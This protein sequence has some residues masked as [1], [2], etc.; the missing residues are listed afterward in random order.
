MRS[1]YA[2]I[3]CLGLAS[4]P[5]RRVGRTWYHK[6]AIDTARLQQRTSLWPMCYCGGNDPEFDKCVTKGAN[7]AIPELVKDKFDANVVAHFSPTEKGGE[8]YW[9][10]KNLDFD[11]KVSKL[12]MNLANLF[13]GDKAL[14]ECD[15]LTNALI[16]PNTKIMEGYNDEFGNI[17]AHLPPPQRT[18]LFKR[19]RSIAITATL[20]GL[21]LFTISILLIKHHPQLN[22][23]DNVY[24]AAIDSYNT[25]DGLLVLRTHPALKPKMKYILHIEYY[26]DLQSMSYGM[27]QISHF[28]DSNTDDRS[29]KTNRYKT[30]SLWSIMT[31]EASKANPSGYQLL[32]THL[33][34]EGI[35]NEWLFL[36]DF[37]ILKV[38]RKYDTS[39]VSFIQFLDAEEYIKDL[40]TP[41]YEVMFTNKNSRHDPHDH[42]NLLLRALIFDWAC[43]MGIGSC[44]ATAKFHFNSWH[45]S[46]NPDEVN[47]S[48]KFAKLEQISSYSAAEALGSDDLERV[49]YYPKKGWFL[50]RWQASVLAIGIILFIFAVVYTGRTT[51]QDVR[52][53]DIEI[54][55]IHHHAGIMRIDFKTPL[56]ASTIYELRIPYRGKVRS[57]PYGLFYVIDRNPDTMRDNFL[58]AT[59]S[60][61][62]YART[63]FPCFDV[64]E[65]NATY[66]ISIA[67]DHLMHFESSILANWESETTRESNVLYTTNNNSERHKR[68]IALVTA[69]HIAEQ[70]IESIITF[71]EDEDKW[72]NEQSFE[73]NT[74]NFIS[75]E[76]RDAADL[77]SVGSIV[78]IRGKEIFC[79]NT[80]TGGYAN[81]LNCS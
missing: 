48:A 62:P 39:E 56:E 52:S 23:E 13:N 72:L 63:I 51:H 55:E 15:K 28:K 24:E 1:I 64:H 21:I 47:P 35:V 18:A 14:G 80:F 67:Q 78:S 53:N 46:D 37:P 12:Y 70:W 16:D 20:A 49:S 79:F 71:P 54:D 3:L 29:D 59:N 22:T 69:A 27:F 61:T 11:F 41:V 10:L 58:I 25:D 75:K 76:E 8:T 43:K 57:L 30:D 38:V 19:F 6:A 66:E 31:D 33:T 4:G 68:K 34:L 17:D 5:A 2:C 77:L 44:Q 73:G 7:L 9:L 74:N 26:G 81:D 45:Q 42:S 65:L 40:I 50:T 32:P 60:D 36:R